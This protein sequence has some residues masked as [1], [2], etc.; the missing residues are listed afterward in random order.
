MKMPDGQQIIW[1]TII[2]MKR[3]IATLV[4]ESYHRTPT[5]R[6]RVRYYFE[7]ILFK[8]STVLHKMGF[9]ECQIEHLRKIYTSL[10]WSQSK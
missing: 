7:R 1:M 10:E 4:Y 5:C 3:P 2:W 9:L 8:T 6:H